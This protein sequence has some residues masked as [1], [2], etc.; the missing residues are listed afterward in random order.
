MQIIESSKALVLKLKNPNRVTTVIPSARLFEHEGEQLV[1]VKHGIEECTVLRNLGF[2]VTSP[3]LYDYDWPRKADILNPFHAQIQTAAFLTLNPRAFVLSEMGC[4]DSDTEYLSPTGWVKISMYAGGKVA[5]YHPD[6]M[7]A[8]FVDPTEIVK[9]P[10]PTMIKIKTKYGIDQMLSPEHRVLLR[11]RDNEFK[12]EVIHASDLLDRHNDWVTGNISQKRKGKIAFSGATIPSVFNGCGGMGLSLTE[13]QLRLQIA[14]IADGYFPNKTNRCVVRLKKDRKTLR[15]RSLLQL[16]GIEWAET[17][18][19]TRTAQGFT[20]FSFQAPLRT[21]EFDNTF[22]AASVIQLEIVCSEVMHW[23]G[24]IRKGGKGAQFS[25]TIKASADFVQYAFTSTGKVARLTEHTRSRRDRVETEYVVTSRGGSRVN[26][27]LQSRSSDGNRHSVMETVPSTDGFKYCFMVPSTFLIFRRNGCV[28]ASG[29]TGK[30]LA[31]LWAADYLMRQGLVH[32]VLIISTLSSLTRVWSDEIMENLPD[33]NSVVLHNT[34]DKRLALLKQDVD[35]YIINHDGIGII[36]KEL[37]K[38]KDIDLIII[39]EIAEYRNANTKGWKIANRIVAPR[40]RAWG[41][42]GTPT[43]QAPS[44][45]FGQVKL[46]APSNVPPYFT[47]FKD[48]VMRQTGPY[49]WIARDNAMDRVFDVMQPSIRYERKEVF[50][51]PDCMYETREASFTP[52]QVRMYKEM[53]KEL[54]MMMDNNQ[55]VAA[56]DAVAASKLL[57]VACGVV[58]DKKKARIS[59]PCEPRIRLVKELIDQ[60]VAKVLIFCPFKSVAEMLRDE[61]SKD[62]KVGMIHG[63]VPQNERNDIFYKFQKTDEIDIIVAHPQTMSHSLTLVA[64]S[65]IIWYSPIYSNE[66]YEQANA[67]ITRPGQKN[68]Q[69]IMHIEGCE[70]ERRVYKKLRERQAMQGTLLDMVKRN[71]I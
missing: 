11:D 15:L 62:Y 65:M 39:D 47:A 57:Q 55:I 27:M 53:I 35:F 34:R 56:N 36:A 22:W 60:S 3:I 46:I 2:K 20:V 64:A 61:L 70:F 29:N 9:I 37:E 51:L 18:K 48:S 71:T 7:T 5:Q 33:R 16:A 45:A 69:F 49:R 30:T 25:T 54:V 8:D 4:V 23:D 66:I 68:K 31:S 40:Q 63:E 24:S 44:D 32:K 17:S 43:P 28:F 58:Y 6:D 14:V 38:R 41:M 10:C 1:A 50:D 12:T 67:R 42:T 59:V 26:L 52:E 19:D 13:A 21:K